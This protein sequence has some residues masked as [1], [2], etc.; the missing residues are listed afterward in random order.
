M[1]TTQI[2]DSVA[3][4]MDH[5]VDSAI[6][7]NDTSE[8]TQMS[9]LFHSSK[10][11]PINLYNKKE[12]AEVNTDWITLHLIII[13]I[14]IALIKVFF[15]KRSKQVLRSFYSN[16]HMNI[17]LREGNIFA[18]RISIG[19]TILY[20][21]T[22]SLFIF[23]FIYVAFPAGFFTLTEYKLFSVIILIVLVSFILKNVTIMMVGKIF[24]N[25][26]LLS[27]FTLMNFIFNVNL[28]LWLLPFLVLSVFLPS[29]EAIYSGFFFWL[30]VFIYKLFRQ[31]FTGLG[32]PNFSLLNRFLYLCALEIVPFLIIIKLVYREL[33]F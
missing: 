16:R 24:K 9:S 10:Q 28:G 4:K 19:A 3:V 23:Q 6:T 8:T 25:H 31:F 2:Q 29:A 1:M 33:Y 21:I 26:L 20:L 12:M 32:Y 7:S 15:A 14:V 17:L 13:L 5:P 22:F 18:E 27:E 30:W 11:S